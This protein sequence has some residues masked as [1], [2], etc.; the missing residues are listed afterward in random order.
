MPLFH[1]DKADVLAGFSTGN[2]KP[3]ENTMIL[4]KAALTSDDDLFYRY[5]DQISDMYINRLAIMRDHVC[6]LLVIIH[7]DHSVD[8]YMNSDVK[9]VV[10]MISKRAITEGYNITID[11]IADIKRLKFQD[12]QILDSDKIIYCFKVGW[13]F[14]LF[15]NVSTDAK[16]KLDLDALYFELGNL[17][18]TLRFEHVYKTIEANQ[19]SSNMM[20]DGWFPFI[21]IIGNDYKELVE[22]YN[23]DIELKSRTLEWTNRFT[24]TRLHRITEKWWT[25]NVYRDKKQILL[26]GI[27]S[28]NIGKKGGYINCIKNLITEIEGVLRNEYYIATNKGNK[29]GMKELC[30]HLMSE[31]QNKTKNTDSLFLPTMFI[32]YLNDVV[33]ANF[34]LENGNI[35][36]S[37]HSSAH[38]VADQNDYSR[39]KAL[40]MILI[41]DQMYYYLKK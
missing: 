15:F 26:A 13:K 9:A 5:I 25:K 6:H 21:D 22:I 38:G 2:A 35:S 32:K 14:G 3:G 16:H 39:E 23:S 4:V 7:F 10:E 37:R 31:A 41:L 20:N 27:E 11:D 18:R 19:L 33:F 1:L 12:T 17:Y 24:E 40:Q 30:E 28:F 34:N 29:V 36:L 8:I